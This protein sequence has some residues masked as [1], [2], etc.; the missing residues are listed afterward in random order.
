M[1]PG[2]SVAVERRRR[3]GPILLEDVPVGLPLAVGSM[4][5]GAGGGEDL[6]PSPGS[7]GRGSRRRVS[8]RW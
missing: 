3:Q 4:A 7:E 5:N 8:G 1:V 2:M 6:L